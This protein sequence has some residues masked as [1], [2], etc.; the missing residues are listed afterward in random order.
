MR[1]IFKHIIS[2]R[3]PIV[4]HNGLLDMCFIYHS[5]YATLPNSL[6]MFLSDL[7][8]MFP[9]GI[10]DTKYVADYVTRETKSFLAYLFRK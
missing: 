8:E 3:V 9:G 2:R 6:D 7:D 1:Q 5:F 4:V 10:Y